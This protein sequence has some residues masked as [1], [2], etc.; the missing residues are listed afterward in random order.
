MLTT[1][2]R[3]RI[4]AISSGGK[5]TLLLDADRTLSPSD[6]GRAVGRHFDVNDRIRG[7][8]ERMGYCNGA[9]EAVANVWS[10]IPVAAY[11]DAVQA[12]A[13]Q[14]R[15]HPAWSMVLTAIAGRIRV[16]VV[17]AGIPQVWRTILDVAGFEQVQVWGGCHAALD[18]YVVSPETKAAVVAAHQQLG[19][20]VIAAGDS[21]VDLPML[22]AADI[23]LFVADA[24]GS[25]R[26]RRRLPEIPG[27]RHFITDDQR[28]DEIP[29]VMSAQLIQDLL[30]IKGGSNAP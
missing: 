7:I 18:D 25:P 29:H 11:L 28:F 8:F 1:L 20:R 10:T 23:A 17:T 22:R 16:E 5:T 14:V 26:L 6:T 13:E 27:I 3:P 4:E 12:E 2:R 30:G 19:R 15:L 21:E 24:K 9:F